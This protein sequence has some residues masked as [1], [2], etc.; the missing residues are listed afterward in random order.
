MTSLCRRSVALNRRNELNNLRKDTR[1]RGVPLDAVAASI[2]KSM[3]L[4]FI[5]IFTYSI[6]DITIDIF[7]TMKCVS[8]LTLD[9]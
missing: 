5:T 8:L 6:L 1:R 3:K 4:E 2:A 9:V 7:L